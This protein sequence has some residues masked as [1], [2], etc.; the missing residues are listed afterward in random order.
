MLTDNLNMRLNYLGGNQKQRMD[1]AKLD[2]L[3]KALLYSYQSETLVTEDGREFRC[4]I[5]PD[6]LKNDYDNKILSIPFE[7]IC[8]NK[9]RV[10][11]TTEGIETTRIKSGDVFHWKETNTDWIIYLQ[12]QEE[13]AYFRGEIRRC[14]YEI[15]INGH[16][17]KI[18]VR[19]PVET[20]V[21]WDHKKRLTW[22]VPNYTLLAYITKNE[23]TLDFFHRFTKVKIDGKPWEVVVVNS[24]GGDGIIEL[25]LTETYNNFLEDE[26]NTIPVIPQ[27]GEDDSVPHIEG[28]TFISP[29]S[30]KTY[31]IKGLSGGKWLIDSRVLDT[32]HVKIISSNE[33]EFTISTGGKSCRFRIVY[34]KEGY[35]DIF[36]P[37]VVE[38]I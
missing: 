36:F 20:K 3:K 5:N 12:Y 26:D 28:D 24:V 14:K 10:G 11:T 31:K 15:D 33:E 13:V 32:E 23:E 18:Y 29:Y 22:S 30:E 27:I 8:L 4:L 16:K 19:G 37:I 17:Y 25:N 38:S 2:S 9:E 6:K 35:D 34:R 21:V 1:R 7:D